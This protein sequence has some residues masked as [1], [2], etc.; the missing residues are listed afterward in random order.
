MFSN[1]IKVRLVAFLSVLVLPGGLFA[2][3]CLTAEEATADL[4]QDPLDQGIN[5]DE[6]GYIV[7]I[8]VDQGQGTLNCGDFQGPGGPMYPLEI[9]QQGGNGSVNDKSVWTVL[10]PDG[11]SADLVFAASNDGKRCT[12]FNAG[13]AK[14]GY[15]AAGSKGN[16]P[17]ILIACTD[18]QE[19]ELPPEPPTPPLP[20]V[21]SFDG[22]CSANPDTAAFQTEINDQDRFDWVIL[23]G[24]PDPDTGEESNTA[25]CIRN[26]AGTGDGSGEMNRCVNRCVVPADE[27]TTGVP[28]YPLGDAARNT[29][30]VCAGSVGPDGDGRF[31]I[32]C[33]VCELSDIVQA[34]FFEE[35]I[36]FCWEQGQDLRGANDLEFP[37]TFKLPQPTQGEQG[38]TVDGV[39]GSTCYLISGRTR[40]GYPYSY[41]APSGCP[42]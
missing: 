42:N 22:D 40:T 14:S 31:P 8:Q 12:Q 25:V 41:W 2:A 20:P 36:P 32:A 38:W 37:N 17:R 1:F 15:A 3:E 19:E 33:R 13:N 18:R 5:P 6:T 34:D 39:N 26:I 4:T 35:D 24:G 30:G 27:A 7:S 29:G 9:T 10:D 21:T 23:G 16:K 11:W 28:W